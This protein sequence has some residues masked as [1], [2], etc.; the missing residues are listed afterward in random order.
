MELIGQGGECYVWRTKDGIFKEYQTKSEAEGAYYWQWELSRWNLAPEVYTRVK[1]IRID[2]ELSGWGYYTE[3]ALTFT[4]DEVELYL[5][6]LYHDDID[7]EIDEINARVEDLFEHEYTDFHIQ[8]Y[9]Y[10]ERNGELVL[11][12]ID[13]T[14]RSF[15]DLAEMEVV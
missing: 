1:R 13:T 6:D 14:L 9:G 8:N 12:I 7:A 11:V 10:I 5:D 3:Q 4:D 2:G 15:C